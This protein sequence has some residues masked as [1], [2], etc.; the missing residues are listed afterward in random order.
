MSTE[1]RDGLTYRAL[2][3][4]AYG[5]RR[6]VSLGVVSAATA[7][8]EL[9][10][11]LADVERG[12]WQPGRRTLQPGRGRRLP[13]AERGASCTCWSHQGRTMK[14]GWVYLIEAADLGLYKIG[15]TVKDPNARLRALQTP[16]PCDLRMECVIRSD[17]PMELES[18]LHAYFASQRVRGEWFRLDSESVGSFAE[19]AMRLDG[20]PAAAA[21]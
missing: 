1:G 13:V 15:M 21:A 20:L 18:R 17:A 8:S 5:K 3:F 12:T 14:S 2:R 16:S 6:Y 9:R 4:T 7:E 19:T 11:V 10:Q